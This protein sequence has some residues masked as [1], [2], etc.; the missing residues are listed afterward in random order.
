MRLPGEE[1]WVI[2]EA[3]TRNEAHV[4]R[5]ELPALWT[6]RDNHVV[7]QTVL[8]MRSTAWLS[9]RRTGDRPLGGLLVAEPDAS[10]GPNGVAR[11]V[12]AVGLRED[13]RRQGMRSD[14]AKRSA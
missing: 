2:E 5:M 10:R 9:E 14:P 3:A 13:A 7:G 12:L 8:V 11:F 1:V 4:L 6:E